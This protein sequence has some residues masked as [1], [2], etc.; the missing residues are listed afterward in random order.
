MRHFLDTQPLSIDEWP[1]VEE[2]LPRLRR[3]IVAYRAAL[4]DEGV[5]LFLAT[6]GC[7]S[8]SALPM[9]WFGYVVA[10]LVFAARMD[11][12][13]TEKKSFTALADGLEQRIAA[14]PAGAEER[15]KQL[16]EL[17]ELRTRLLS[18]LAGFRQGQVFLACWLFYG[19]SC[20]W[21][22]ISFAKSAA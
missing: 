19:L 6:L 13:S 16:L 9:Q 20:L 2:A 17:R 5:W 18:P 8:V 11:L 22:V 12:R 1:S 21:S 14:L 15:T 3:H 7:W 10:F 4:T